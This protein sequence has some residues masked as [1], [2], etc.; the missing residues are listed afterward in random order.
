MRHTSARPVPH[1]ACLGL[2]LAGAVAPPQAPA[3]PPP[4]DRAAVHVSVETFAID[5]KGTWSAGSDEADL[6]PGTAGVLQKSVTL[7]GKDRNRTQDQVTITARLTPDAGAPQEAACVL[8]AVFETRRGAGRPDAAPIDR[9]D[10]GVTIAP[11]EERLID[12]Y[13][14]PLNDG[15]VAMRVRCAPSRPEAK[16]VPDMV[17]L[18]V[19]VEKDAEGEP[20]EILRS[21]RL[22][23][24]LGREA[25]TVVTANAT[26][27]DAED[28]SKRYRREEI[29]AVLT[30]LIIVAGKLQIDVRV[31]GEIATVGTGG[32]RVRYPI[33]HSETF[34]VAPSE[35]RSFK[36]EIT[37]RDPDEGWKQV[38]LTVG[39]IARF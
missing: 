3:A 38:T 17:T 36:V 33:D 15:R 25:G 18:D 12:V 30:P 1:A 11:G 35:P 27:P 14:S 21:Q 23:A 13:A 9:R 24:T 26:L 34:V 32:T 39:V 16:S 19:S 31:T 10:A 6:F 29:E 2:L 5:R 8:H 20:P 37:A 28:G 7:T 4:A 22:V